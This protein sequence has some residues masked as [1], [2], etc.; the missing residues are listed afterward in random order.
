M[1][2]SPPVAL[3]VCARLLWRVSKGIGAATA[4]ATAKVAARLRRVEILLLDRDK[5]PA[6]S[7]CGEARVR[8]N[9]K[10]WVLGGCDNSVQL[11]DRDGRL[12]LAWKDG[13]RIRIHRSFG[14]IRS[15]SD[16]FGRKLRFRYSREGLRVI[17]RKGDWSSD[18][19]R[20]GYAIRSVSPGSGPIVYSYGADH[21]LADVGYTDTT[22]LR[23]DYDRS[24]RVAKLTTREGDVYEFR[25][26]P[27]TDETLVI[28]RPNKGDAS[29]M[30]VK[31]LD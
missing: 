25:Y 9:G 22:H 10:Y 18:F 8:W 12:I 29:G 28:R 16:N 4:T 30:R 7:A 19:D 3:Q 27:E 24:G 13:Y 2:Q 14:R 6:A 1:A 15:L 20:D 17:S 23:I 5:A 21:K 26:R 31:F 11:F